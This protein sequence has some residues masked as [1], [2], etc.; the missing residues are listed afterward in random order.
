MGLA[1]N[2]EPTPSPYIGA[3]PGIAAGPHQGL[4]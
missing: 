4:P 2:L 3:V 1:I